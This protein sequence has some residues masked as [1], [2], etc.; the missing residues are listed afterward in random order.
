M[1]LSLLISCATTRSCKIEVFIRQFRAALED[2][3]DATITK[4][5]FCTIFVEVEVS[6][7]LVI[8]KVETLLIKLLFDSLHVF[9]TRK[10]GRAVDTEAIGIDFQ[11]VGRWIEI[12]D[13]VYRFY[14]EFFRYGECDFVVP[15]CFLDER[16]V[17]HE[18]EVDKY[19][20]YHSW[21]W[22]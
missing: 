6:L 12:G 18:L 21:V 16:V 13:F 17:R 9:A 2:G 22:R 7:L 14:F 10:G 5:F 8:E 1:T 15:L 4:A 11:G 19:L 20:M 3:N